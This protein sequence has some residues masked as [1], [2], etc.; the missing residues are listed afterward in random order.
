MH[1][2]YTSTLVLIESGGPGAVGHTAAVRTDSHGL[3]GPRHIIAAVAAP[4][5]REAGERLIST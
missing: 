5:A 4:G 1:F 2:R 3:A